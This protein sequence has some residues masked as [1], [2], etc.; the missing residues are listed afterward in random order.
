METC[1]QQSH[2]R[3]Y[4]CTADTAARDTKAPG[5]AKDAEKAKADGYRCRPDMLKEVGEA[6]ATSTQGGTCGSCGIATK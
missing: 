6:P 1:T 5:N 4:E 3:R 2:A